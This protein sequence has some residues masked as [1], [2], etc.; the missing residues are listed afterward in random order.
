MQEQAPKRKRKKKKKLFTKIVSDLFTMIIIIGSIYYGIKFVD[1]PI[2]SFGYLEIKGNSNITKQEILKNNGILEPFNFFK[3][4]ARTIQRNLSKDL[5]IENVNVRHIWPNKLVIDLTEREPYLCLISNYGFVQIDAKGQI[6]N[7]T[8]N[9]HDGKAIFLFGVSAEN[10]YV[11]DYIKNIEA[12]E[13]LK[14]LSR[15]DQQ[16]RRDILEIK[17]D[18]NKVDF[19]TNNKVLIKFGD[20]QNL[21]T[22]L[23]N[24]IFI[25][26]DIKDKNIL[27]DYIDLSFHKPFVNIAK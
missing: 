26:N 20:I 25:V 1:H 13:V 8:K 15:L 4:N 17:I 7:A 21:N 2:T 9:V 12:L 3:V 16:N 11:G 23:D 10:L 5:R 27:V 24:Y 14:F 19:L 6:I 18:N 22:K